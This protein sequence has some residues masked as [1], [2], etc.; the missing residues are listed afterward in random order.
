MTITH[1][2]PMTDDQFAQ[3]MAAKFAAI[4]A[5]QAVKDLVASFGAAAAMAGKDCAPMPKTTDVTEE[6]Y[7][8]WRVYAEGYDAAA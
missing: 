7:D 4:K 2:P 3:Y 6:A 8:V 1:L 5:A